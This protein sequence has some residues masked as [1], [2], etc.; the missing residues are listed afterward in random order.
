[1][2][3]FHLTFGVRFLLL[4]NYTIIKYGL[5]SKPTLSITSNN[6][7]IA[8]FAVPIEMEMVLFEGIVLKTICFYVKVIMLYLM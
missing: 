5:N 6:L 2:L 7:S 4:L 3:D 1:M 8:L